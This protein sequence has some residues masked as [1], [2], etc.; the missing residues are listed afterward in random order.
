MTNISFGLLLCV[1]F[2][3]C[4][5]SPEIPI[6]DTLE[7]SLRNRYSKYV[8]LLNKALER[9][10]SALKEFLKIDNIYDAA[11]YDHGWVLIELMKKIGDEKFSNSMATLTVQQKNNIKEYFEVGMQGMDRFNDTLIKTYPKTSELLQ[12]D[13]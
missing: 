4:K 6:S 5:P 13:K 11:G 2:S 9:D 7:I 8:S 3:M 12:F 1:L 10:T